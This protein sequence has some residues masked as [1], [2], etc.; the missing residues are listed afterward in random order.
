V[1]A[2]FLNLFSRSL[3]RGGLSRLRDL[4]P[5]SAE[6]KQVHEERERFAAAA[7]AFCLEYDSEFRRHFWQ[8]ICKQRATPRRPATPHVEVEPRRWTD[9]LLKAKNVLCAIEM[10]IGAPVLQL[11][12]LIAR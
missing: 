4:N 3:Y 5:E 1:K 12:F 7:I 11:T 9:L 6:Y 10:K 2:G 8:A